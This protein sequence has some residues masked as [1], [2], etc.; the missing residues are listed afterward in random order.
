[1]GH[2]KDVADDVDHTSSMTSSVMYEGLSAANI[3]T[4]KNF[5]KTVDILSAKL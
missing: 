2:E 3:S 5:C 4:Y 1:M